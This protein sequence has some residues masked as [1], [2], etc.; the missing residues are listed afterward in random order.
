MAAENPALH[1]FTYC[2]A[3]CY[4]IVY[5]SIRR[6]LM[7][8]LTGALIFAA[9]FAMACSRTPGSDA[10][11]GAHLVTVNNVK[12]SK[13]DINDELAMLPPE[14]IKTFEEQGGIVALVRELAKKEMIYQEA[15]ARGILRDK[16]FNRR[17][18]LLKKRLAV[19]MLL[20]NEIA[21]GT[22]VTDQEVR[23]YY[24][25]RKESFVAEVPGNGKKD[26]MEF[27]VV[28]DYIK[29][30]L[31]AE[32]QRAAF[33]K[34]MQSLMEKYSISLNEEAIKAAFGNSITP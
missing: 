33:E 25:S 19:E 10:E 5:R 34:Y 22:T 4:N 18:N 23:D 6:D 24:E 12:L 1:R 17:L 29:K 28:K 15:A 27:E 31:A 30:R 9:F 7:R 2:P 3:L 32:K 26:I 8:Y 13:E 16:E 11:K 14:V 20:E 21:K